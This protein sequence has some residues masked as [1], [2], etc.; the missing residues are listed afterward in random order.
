MHVSRHLQ[1]TQLIAV[2]SDAHQILTPFAPLY[3]HAAFFKFALLL[4]CA[5]ASI[6]GRGDRVLPPVQL[7][8]VR[9]A[10]V[11]RDRPS[12][13]P[14]PPPW[15]PPAPPALT[16]IALARSWLLPLQTPLLA[17]SMS[18]ATYVRAPDAAA[19]P[20][21]A[22]SAQYVYSPSAPSVIENVL[23]TILNPG[24]NSATFTVLNSTLAFLSFC[25]AL[26]LYLFDAL[27]E[28]V[29][30]QLWIFLATTVALQLSVNW[31]MCRYAMAKEEEDEEEEEGE[32]EVEEVP[33]AAAKTKV[34]AAA[35]AGKAPSARAA[36]AARLA[37]SAAAA[38]K[39]AQAAADAA[40]AAAAAEEEVEAIA[41]AEAE[42]EAAPDRVVTQRS[43]AK[44]KSRKVV[45]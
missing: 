40:A 9:R 27:S 36:A 37:E 30:F 23:T 28:K 24:V 38:A 2:R 29:R 35:P 21:S 32:E 31:F 11:Y 45:D 5:V 1:S 19:A 4:L 7:T 34:A 43:N 20:A 6:C 15:P 18:R 8:C 22:A 12:F 3:S 44:K 41:E 14:A 10:V 39:A 25:I 16:L 42:A 17:A 13:A 26:M 33:V